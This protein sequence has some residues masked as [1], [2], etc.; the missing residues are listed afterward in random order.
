[1]NYLKDRKQVTKLNGTISN[2][3]TVHNGVPQGSILGPTLFLIYGYDFLKN[4]KFQKL[5]K[6][7][8]IHR[9]TQNVSANLSDIYPSQNLIW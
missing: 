3:V 9:P 7:K 2:I 6:I 1:M 8:K 4:C 5:R